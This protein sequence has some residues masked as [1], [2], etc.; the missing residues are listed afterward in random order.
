MSVGKNPSVRS[1]DVNSESSLKQSLQS[2]Q[3]TRKSI[4]LE[5]NNE[6]SFSEPSEEINPLQNV[7]DFE[8]PL[9]KRH[10]FYLINNK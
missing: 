3:S 8:Y 1:D 6:G 4:Y 7:L 9:K 5:T 10:H 2:D